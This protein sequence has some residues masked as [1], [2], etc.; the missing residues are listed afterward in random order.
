MPVSLIEKWSVSS[1]HDPTKQKARLHSVGKLNRVSKQVDKDLA[2]PS[3][4]GENESRHL[5]RNL[6]REFQR[7]FVYSKRETAESFLHA[8]RQVPFRN[9]YIEL[10]RLNFC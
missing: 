2:K 10:L 1:L 3:L 5:R 9:L 4:I 7:L 8:V 6:K